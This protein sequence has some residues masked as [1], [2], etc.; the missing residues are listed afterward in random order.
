MSIPIIMLAA[1]TIIIVVILLSLSII[2]DVICVFVSGM[3]ALGL[4]V[5]TRA[6]HLHL[7]MLIR[8]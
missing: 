1:T 6:E 8:V 4:T 2:I 3:L 5:C 7:G